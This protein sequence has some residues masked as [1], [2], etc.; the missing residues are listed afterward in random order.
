MNHKLLL[1]GLALSP[2]MLAMFP[3]YAEDEKEAEQDIEVIEV[4]GFKSS[5]TKALNSKRFAKNVTESIAAEDIGKSADQ[6]IAEALQRVTGIS[7]DRSGGEGTTVSVRGAGP[8]LNNITLNGVPLTSSGQNQSVDL[9]QYSSDVLSNITVVKTPS[10]DHDEGSLGASIQLNGFKPLQ[11]A[12]NRRVIEVQYRNNTFADV[13]G[14]PDHKLSGSLSEKFLDETVGFS[15]VASTEASTVRRDRYSNSW[16]RPLEPKK[17]ATNI[18]TG[19]IVTKDDGYDYDGDGEIS[20][21][22]KVIRGFANRQTQYR[23]SNLSRDRKTVSSTLQFLPTEDTDVSFNFTFSEQKVKNDDNYFANTTPNKGDEPE[24]ILWDPSTFTFP[25]WTDTSS[26][27]KENIVVRNHRDITETTNTNHVFGFN[28]D[29]Q[30]ENFLFSF[31]AGHSASESGDDFYLQSRYRLPTSGKGQGYTSGYDCTSLS[32]LCLS[33]VSPELA[34]DPSTMEL[35]SLALRD[36]KVEDSATN[37]FFDIDWEVDFGPVTTVEFG[38]KWSQREKNIHETRQEFNTSTFGDFFDGKTMA[39]YNDGEK[40]PSDWGDALGFPRDEITNGWVKA[41]SR[42]ILR[43]IQDAG[44]VPEI[45]TN[46]RNTRDIETEAQ[47]AYAKVNFELF[48]GDLVGDIG[49]RYAQTDVNS[50]GYSGFKYTTLDFITEEN[51]AYYGSEEAAF[52]ALGLRILKGEETPSATPTRGSHDYDNWLPSLNLNYSLTDDMIVRFAT[53]KTMARPRIDAL[54]P[55][56]TITESYTNPTSNASLGST[57][58]NPYLST[59]LDLSFE[60]YFDKSSLLAVTLFNKDMSDFEETSSSLGYWQD[61]RNEFYDV[62]DDGRTGELKD[63]E[64]I[65]FVANPSDVILDYTPG[66]MPAGCMPNR[67]EDMGAAFGDDGCDL[68]NLSIERNGKGGYVRGMEFNFQHNFEYLPGA[69]SGLG[70]LTNYTYSDSE[71]DEERDEE[72]NI[73]FA[74]SPLPD[75]SEHTFNATVFWEKGDTLLRVAYNNRSD[76]L[77]TRAGQDG[78]AVW[79][80]GYDSLDFS[81]SY[82]IN[83]MISINFQ[84]VNL[85][86]TVVRT[87]NSNVVDPL[88]PAEAL[89]LGDAPDHRTITASNV[90]TT[91]RLS[92]RINF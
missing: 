87:Y 49:L 57:E 2:L 16:W 44:L 17:G 65:D 13:D 11:A 81:A 40:T 14:T 48:D 68:L 39:D 62:A 82:Q 8:N 79:T 24:N 1:A 41:D 60:W 58:L 38:L 59:N 66:S 35:Q 36:R 20:D 53:S 67:E 6:N 74:A 4:K 3:A 9:S 89:T 26:N 22:E 29:H 7:I 23:T 10:A 21:D 28:I 64:D 5:V 52:E 70:L 45:T 34:N 56:F 84:A 27:P 92:T 12:K 72:G 51:I 76:Y 43:D 63:D 54:K 78:N 46:L 80:E 85:T 19:E 91:Y 18:E 33:V 69:L 61:V 25:K 31:K 15:L 75:T 90:G 30:Y 86:D 47:A 83:K 32:D 77:D 37:V 88:L 50:F 55:G 71:V 42:A 73:T